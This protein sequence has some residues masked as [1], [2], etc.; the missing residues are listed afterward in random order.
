MEISDGVRLIEQVSRN[1]QALVSYRILC[2][3]SKL[4][5][6][7]H[8]FSIEKNPYNCH[9]NVFMKAAKKNADL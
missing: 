9:R 1:R 7:F 8:L 6:N 3:K 4:P 2:I 5:L